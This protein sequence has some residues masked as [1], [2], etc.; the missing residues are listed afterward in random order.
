MAILLIV[1][2]VALGALSLPSVFA[3]V[4]M[5]AGVIIVV[6][7]GLLAA[8]ACWICGEM[9]QTYSGLNSYVDAGRQLFVPLGPK[10]ARFGYELFSVLFI[11]LLIF[12]FASHTLTGAIMWQTLTEAPQVCSLAF[13]G[14][15]AALLAILAA[16]PTFHDFSWLGYVDFISII[17]AILITMISTGITAHNQPGGLS[18]VDWSAWPAPGTDFV[19]AFGAVTQVVFAYAFVVVQFTFHSEMRE[20]KDIKKS[21]WAVVSVQITIYVLTG[22]LIY[23]F[24]G[25]NV[26]S[27]ALLSAPS[28]TLTRI[29]FGVALPVIFISGSINGAVVSRYIH[30]RIFARSRH[31]FI[32]TGPGWL[33]WLLILAIE[34]VIAFCISEAIPFF[35]TLLGL[36][37]SVFLSGFCFYV[38]PIM[39]F[40]SI[41]QGSPFKR[42]NIKHTVASG[43]TF[44]FG[45]VVLGAGTYASADAIKMMYTQGAVRKPFD[46][47]PIE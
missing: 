15:S 34:G 3:T 18:S 26:Q 13:V 45:V 38:P 19:S 31:R 42:Q 14:I 28:A 12:N 43:F 20:P 30:G 17:A 46:C 11:V 16:P 32:N 37:A 36:I 35:N 22:A 10:W 25:Q 40:C 27:P 5:V 29:A 1:E 7:T 8:Y 47:A 23:V 6:G 41:R 24:V 21:I 44:I 4:G 9:Y 33:V 2:S 39:W